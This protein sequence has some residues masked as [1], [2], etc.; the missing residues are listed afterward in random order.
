MKYN[1]KD[2][3]MKRTTILIIAAVMLSCCVSHKKIIK[4]S[5]AQNKDSSSIDNK[6]ASDYLKFEAF[7]HHTNESTYEEVQIKNG[8]LIYTY[9]KDEKGDC[10]QWVQQKPCWTKDDLKTKEAVLSKPEMDSLF[11]KVEKLGY[12]KLDTVIGN[13]SSTERYYTFDLSFKTAVKEKD[14]L[15]KS[16]PGGVAM[17][18]AFRR[19]RDLLMKM[20]W[21]K[22][23]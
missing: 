21:E 22:M 11:T 15:F 10:A 1:L 5:V 16:V 12:W 6:T 23:K 19:S 14:V 3:K 17:P 2:H 8:K 7:Y 4:Q 20:V 9:F 13:P 18:D